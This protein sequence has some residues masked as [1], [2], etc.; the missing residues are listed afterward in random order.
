MDHVLH[1]LV[2]LQVID[3]AIDMLNMR[4]NEYPERMK[5]L[6]SELQKAEQKLSDERQHVE[7]LEKEQRHYERELQNANNDKDKHN[8][9]MLAIKTNEEYQAM[10]KE[11]ET[12]KDQIEKYEG[13][14]LER[15]TV[16]DDFSEK[17]KDLEEKYNS[18]KE[19]TDQKTR[20]FEAEL[21]NIEKELDL[22][23]QEREKL[24]VNLNSKLMRTYERVRGKNRMAVVAVLKGACGGCFERLPPQRINEIRH[25][26]EFIYCENC[27]SILVWDEEGVL[28]NNL[29]GKNRRERLEQNR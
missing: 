9:R 25:N 1:T 7:E 4:K 16:L 3:S 15:M 6:E 13:Q 20:E 14:I 17:M 26:E 5:I 8:A 19:H 18:K 11:I 21:D 28:N 29:N 27:G 22:R 2:Q 10:L 23:Q 24:V 12:L